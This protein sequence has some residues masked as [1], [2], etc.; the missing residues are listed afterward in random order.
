MRWRSL[1][2]LAATLVVLAGAYYAL[3]ARGKKSG[4]DAKRLFVADD[5]EVEQISIRRKTESIIVRRDGGEWRLVEPVRAKTNG[6]E[7]DSLLHVILNARQER[8]IDDQPKSL[9][10]FG[11]E[12][13][14]IA[15][16][17]TLQGGRSLPELLLGDKNPNGFSVYAKRGNQPAVFLVAENLRSRL[18]RKADDLRD[19]TL[20]PLDLDKVKQVTLIHKGRTINLTGGDAR[21]WE[22]THP[23]KT[24]ADGSMV[25]DLL[26]KIKDARVKEFLARPADS[27]RRYGLEHPDLIVELREA[28]VPKRLLLKTPPDPKAGLYALAEPGEGIVSTDARLLT[29][30]ARSP[31]ELRDRSLLR[32]ETTDVVSLTIRRRG[33]SLSVAKEGDVWKLKTPAAGDAQAGK[34]YDLLYALKELR[35]HALVA[36]TRREDARYG[37]KSP[38]IEVE[39][40]LA[41]GSRLPALLIGRSANDRLY[42]KLAASP[43]IYTIDPKFLARIPTGPEALTQGSGT[44]TDK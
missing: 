36:Q 23:T 11:L 44:K 27:T 41:D 6:T 30:L 13:P 8:G 26:W 2:V 28:D 7:I 20:L 33:Q 35:Y 40:G 16:T 34:I 38:E 10:E 32:F 18:D 17:V 4:D 43:E 42:A 12:Q 1:G 31:D 29:D 37:L 25:R 15:L 19:R 39:L 21:S 3:E 5:K 24:R 9:I 14:A 22:M